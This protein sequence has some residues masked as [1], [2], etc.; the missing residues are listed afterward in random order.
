MSGPAPRAV[1]GE[2]PQPRRAQP[3]EVRVGVGHQF[4]RGLGRGVQRTRTVDALRFGKRRRRRIAVDRRRTRVHQVFDAAMPAQLQHVDEADQVAV[5]V[6]VRILERV[7]HAGL[8]GEMDHAA[9]AVLVE[10]RFERRRDP[11]RS[12]SRDLD[13]GAQRGDA[14]ALELRIVVVVEVVQADDVRAARAQFAAGVGADETGGAGDED[15]VRRFGHGVRS[16]AS[17]KLPQPSREAVQTA[18]RHCD[19]LLGL[20]AQPFEHAVQRV[21]VGVV[22]HQ[23]AL[24]ARARAAR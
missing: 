4:V 12:S 1:H 23:P 19:N 13:V 24:A 17:Q 20:A 15:G 8:R 6:G 9:E 2:E 11:C 3:V 5:D 10:Q 18:S 16:S 21:Q 7:A 14:I 22:D